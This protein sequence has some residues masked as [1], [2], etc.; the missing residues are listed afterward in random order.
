[1][2]MLTHQSLISRVLCSVLVVLF[3]FLLILSSKAM[4]LVMSLWLHW[5]CPYFSKPSGLCPFLGHFACTQFLIYFLSVVSF[6]AC[7]VSVCM[8]LFF[9]SYICCYFSVVQRQLYTHMRVSRE[10]HAHLLRIPHEDHACT[11]PKRTHVL[12]YAWVVYVYM[13]LRVACA[14]KVQVSVTVAGGS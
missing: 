1:M 5:F 7:C 4:G 3:Q 10:N 6:V 13:Y 14:I 9:C 12:L 11:I 8:L 2:Y